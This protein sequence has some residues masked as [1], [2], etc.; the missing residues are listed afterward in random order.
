MKRQFLTAAILATF[1]SACRDDLSNRVENP[2]KYGDEVLFGASQKAAE[3]ACS[4]TEYGTAGDTGIPI[5]WKTDGSDHIK[6]YCAEA[7]QTKLIEYSVIPLDGTSQDPDGVIS[8][9]NTGEAGLQ[10]G[11]SKDHTFYAFYPATAVHEIENG[12]VKGEIL[13]SQTPETWEQTTEEGVTVWTGKPNMNYAYMTA[14]T[15][16]NAENVEE[17]ASVP[18]TFTP[19]VTVLDLTITAGEECS[20][21]SLVITTPEDYGI[22]G[23]FSYDMNNDECSATGTGTVQNQISISTWKNNENGDPEPIHLKQNDKIN[24]KAFLLPKG[25][26]EDTYSGQN[27]KVR[28]VGVN[29][30][31]NSYGP[32]TVTLTQ[33]TIER[34]KINKATLNGFTPGK[35]NRWMTSLNQNI[36]LTELSIPGSYASYSIMANGSL[37]SGDGG[38]TLPVSDWKYDDNN[39]NTIQVYQSLSVANQFNSGVRAF[40]LQMRRSNFGTDGDLYVC[41]NAN[42]NIGTLTQVLTNFAARLDALNAADNEGKVGKEF[43]ILNIEY[44]QMNADYA[45]GNIHRLSWLRDVLKEIYDW[46]NTSNNTEK[47]YQEYLT[48]ET[49]LSDLANK[50]VLFINYPDKIE[51][52]NY[53]EDDSYFNQILTQYSGLCTILRGAT[54]DDTYKPLN[55]VDIE[56]PYWI[57]PVGNARIKYRVQKLLRTQ[58]EK[59]NIWPYQYELNNGDKQPEGNGRYKQYL[60]NNNDRIAK[61]K[62]MIE[63]LFEY[64]Q[65][66]NLPNEWYSNML[67]GF[68]V[69]SDDESQRCDHGFG[70][71]TPYHAQLMNEYAYKYLRGKDL[72]APL[73]MVFMNFAGVHEVDVSGLGSEVIGTTTVY[74]DYMVQTL[75]DNNF[76]FPL[77]KAE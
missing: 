14:K 38:N 7:A 10:W 35:T 41:S 17:G 2:V 4:R 21:S 37:A 40:T 9:I 74:G 63:D 28:V 53:D 73:G 12:I 77:R 65:N 11:G 8:K 36:Y 44:R 22:A 33:N 75:I 64:T 1:I 46:K 60:D 51:N 45:E 20:V 39:P 34:S 24:V 62:G 61:K 59:L 52:D 6:I 72:T 69:T 71:D 55:S 43:V 50:I 47:I 56:Q 49:K 15:V 23:E 76:K 70:G 54:Y 42:N 66:E 30:E 68:C 57:N 25:K 31:T 13:A 67:G 27:I 3:D 29:Q 19:L 18:L 5:Y 26:L 16:I 48:E 58:N 32:K